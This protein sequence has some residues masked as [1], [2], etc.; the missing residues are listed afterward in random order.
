[1]NKSTV[2]TPAQLATELQQFTGSETSYFR[3]AGCIRVNYSEGV[4][5]LQREAG[6]YWLVDLIAGYQTAEFKAKDYRQFWKLS[7]DVKSRQ[8]TLTCDDGNGNIW[9]T[10]QVEY[11][12][13]TLPE[14][15]I[16]IV[17]D[18]RIFMYLPSEH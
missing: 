15:A 10:K 13:F 12:D 11:T 14:I 9:V 2:M 16:W 3:M 5:F 17:V 4:K 1:M 7:V 18:E 8:G 6:C